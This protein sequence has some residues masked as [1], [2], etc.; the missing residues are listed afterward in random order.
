MRNLVHVSATLALL[1][2]L[3]GGAP[4]GADGAVKIVAPTSVEAPQNAP[5]AVRTG[6]AVERVAF[7]VDGKRRWVDESPSWQFGPSGYLSTA[8]LASG[9]HALVVKAT[10][11]SGRV[12]RAK[13]L[14]RVSRRS[15]TKERGRKRDK[16]APSPEPAPVPEPTPEPEPAPEPEPTPTPEPQATPVPEPTPEPAPEQ[17][18]A[19]E[20]APA[21]APTGKVLFRGDFD[22]G[23]NG[24]YVQS[25]LS[26]AT[27]FSSG[28]FEGAQA[29]RFEVRD[30]DVEPDTG[31][32]RSEVSGPTFDEGQDLY[33]RNAIRVPSTNTYSAPWQIVQQLHEEN[34]PGS[35]GIAVFLDNNRALKLGAGDSSPMYWKGA[36][37]QTG[38]WYDLV[39][40]VY[41]SQDS[42][43]GFVEVWLDG[44]QQ[45]LLN[46]QKRMYGETIQVAQTYI[47]AG[48]YRS[49]SSTGTSV[50][51]H[52]GIVVGTSLAAVAAAG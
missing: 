32:E 31:S 34:W 30:G 6:D 10:H 46:G 48:I 24:W 11:E 15:A 36:A 3:L 43:K 26:R 13:R 8:G 33:I 40:R 38:R 1:L 14:I 44:V 25:L 50:V 16:P 7:Y 18:P 23:F 4:A 49:K 39:Y 28:A 42:S 41:L 21:P 47:K 5:V 37:L 19:P 17:A 22:G 35:P 52:D 2:A 45:T 29:A 51:E 27:L 9:S 12:V 20:P